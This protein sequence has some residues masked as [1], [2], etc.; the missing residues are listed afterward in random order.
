MTDG[1]LTN[2]PLE[3]LEVGSDSEG[4]VGKYEQ[5]F[6]LKGKVEKLVIDIP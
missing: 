2:Q 3:P 4:V 5:P 6:P 1:C